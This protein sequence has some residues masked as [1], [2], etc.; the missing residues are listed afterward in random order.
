MRTLARNKFFLRLS[1]CPVPTLCSEEECFKNPD[2]NRLMYLSDRDPRIL[3]LCTH[4]GNDP[5][6]EGVGA[7]QNGFLMVATMVGL[8]PN[9]S[10]AAGISLPA[11]QEALDPLGRRRS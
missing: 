11:L 5:P 7:P 4:H 1:L 6:Y 9:R 10:L 2:A 3:L 8:M